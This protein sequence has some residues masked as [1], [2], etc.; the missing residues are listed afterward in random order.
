MFTTLPSTKCNLK[1]EFQNF[2]LEILLPP[3]KFSSQILL[4]FPTEK[5]LDKNKETIGRIYIINFSTFLVFIY[6]K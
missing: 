3:S 1:R 6:E 4:D 5:K 2:L